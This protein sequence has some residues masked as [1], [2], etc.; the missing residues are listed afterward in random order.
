MYGKLLVKQHNAAGCCDINVREKS[1]LLC[2]LLAGLS[3][4]LVELFPLRKKRM[5]SLV[6]F[7]V[8]SKS[9]GKVVGVNGGNV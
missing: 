3:R 1:V 2:V 7:V 9:F 5:K 8:D 4:S 6:I